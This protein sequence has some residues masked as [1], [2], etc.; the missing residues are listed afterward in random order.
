MA[1]QI[2]FETHSITEGNERD[3]ATG[4]Q[5]G[6]LSEKGR[7]LA[8]ELG[9]RRRN[10]RIQAV[11]TSDLRRAVETAEIAFGETPIPERTQQ[12]GWEYSLS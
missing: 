6:R 4:W 11:F 7:L 3:I 10:D 8:K 9:K 1:I 5:H 12:A 2:V